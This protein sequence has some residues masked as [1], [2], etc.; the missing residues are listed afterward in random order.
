MLFAG[1]VNRRTFLRT[2]AASTAILWSIPA[3][4]AEG[5]SAPPRDSEFLQKAHANIDRYRRTAIS[6]RVENAKGEPIRNA[7][8]S[9]RQQAHE[10]LFGCNFFQFGRCANDQQEEQYRTQFAQLFNYC[11]LGFYW[12]PYELERGKPSYDYTDRVLEWTERKGINCKGH[13]LVW[14]HPAGSPRWLPDNPT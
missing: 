13:P 11:T 14:D 1:G 4:C 7:R 5:D 10:F 12:A 8:V 9:I 2:G 3:W 6:V